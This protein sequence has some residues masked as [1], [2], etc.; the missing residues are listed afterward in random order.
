[1]AMWSIQS[2]ADYCHVVMNGTCFTDGDGQY[3]AYERCTVAA[4]QTL[5]VSTTSLS[6]E[7][8][9][10][11][12]VVNGIAYSGEGVENGPNGDVL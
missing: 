8:Y 2:G 3:F 1:M 9:F 4:T 6:T 11:Y 12:L 5:T 10:D 7:S